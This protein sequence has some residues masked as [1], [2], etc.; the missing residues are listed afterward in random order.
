MNY[1]I[2]IKMFAQT[3]PRPMPMLVRAR[4]RGWK[5]KEEEEEQEGLLSRLFF[6][7][8][9]LSN[10][11]FITRGFTIVQV[12]L[13][14]FYRTQTTVGVCV[15][16]PYMIESCAPCVTL[17]SMIESCARRVF[18]RSGSFVGERCDDSDS[19]SGALWKLRITRGLSLSIPKSFRE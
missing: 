19:P 6:I 13:M 5:E 11:P 12:G 8:N 16:S 10:L 14:W 7:S 1:L 15:S 9:Q 17:R 4:V 18:D 2:G 3:G